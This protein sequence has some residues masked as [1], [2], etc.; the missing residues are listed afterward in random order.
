MWVRRR[1]TAGRRK[2]LHVRG[3]ATPNSIPHAGQLAHSRAWQSC[4]KQTLSCLS[5]AGTSLWALGGVRTERAHKLAD[6]VGAGSA[7]H[8]NNT[9][10]FIHYHSHD[11]VI[12]LAEFVCDLRSLEKRNRCCDKRREQLTSARLASTALPSRTGRTP[13]SM[14]RASC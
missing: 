7:R 10:A 6:G 2:Q 1:P 11:V 4:E 9:M 12:Q 13:G 14:T 3:I 8:L 5:L